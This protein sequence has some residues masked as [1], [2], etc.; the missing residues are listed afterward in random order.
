MPAQQQQQLAAH[1]GARASAPQRWRRRVQRVDAPEGMLHSAPLPNH[2]SILV[3][4]FLSLLTPLT[5]ATIRSGVYR[6]KQLQLPDAVSRKL[7]FFW[8]T[9][10]TSGPQ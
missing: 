6:L 8:P 10:R 9:D 1:T 7:A 5:Y 2:N 3:V 4:A